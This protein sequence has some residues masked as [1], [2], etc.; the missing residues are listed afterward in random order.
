MCDGKT[1]YYRVNV[2]K[3]E[4]KKSDNNNFFFLIGHLLLTYWIECWSMKTLLCCLLGL[5][6]VSPIVQCGTLAKCNCQ[7][8]S[9]QWMQEK[10]LLAVIFVKGY[11]G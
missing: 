8:H 7:S 10:Q 4:K 2:K 1:L 11:H 5:I 3:K 9:D 6:E